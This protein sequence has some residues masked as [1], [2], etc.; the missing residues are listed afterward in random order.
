MTETPS[1]ANLL[2]LRLSAAPGSFREMN[3]VR[4]DARAL[5]AGLSPE[6]A[7]L[8]SLRDISTADLIDL[9]ESATDGAESRLTRTGR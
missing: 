2:R 7:R 6:L 9:V 5:L 3:S 1:A 8:T 4:S